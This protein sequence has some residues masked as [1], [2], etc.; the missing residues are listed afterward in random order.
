M[1]TFLASYTYIFI[2]YAQILAGTV[3]TSERVFIGDNISRPRRFPAQNLGVATLNSSRIEAQCIE[4]SSVRIAGGLGVEP[5]PHLADPPT[6]GQNSTPGV[7][8]Q[9]PTYVL[10]K[11]VCCLLHTSF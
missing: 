3:T 1:M 5:L 4:L 11:L 9:P 8:F 6:S 10:P 7:E 2:H